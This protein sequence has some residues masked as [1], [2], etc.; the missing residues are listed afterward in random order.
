[1]PNRFLPANLSTEMKAILEH[2][3][4]IDKWLSQAEQR[5]F[6]IEGEYLEE[7]Q[8]QGNIVRGW[9]TSVLRGRSGTE[10]TTKDRLFSSCSYNTW[11]NTKSHHQNYANSTYSLQDQQSHLQSKK[12]SRRSTSNNKCNSVDP[13]WD[14]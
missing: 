10:D 14:D 13:D 7:T 2:Q 4:Q 8:A 5:I 3:K 11:I 12:K 9:D 6:D 1:M